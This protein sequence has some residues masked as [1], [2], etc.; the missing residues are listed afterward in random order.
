MKQVHA[1]YYNL[2]SLEKMEVNI[3]LIN[4]IEKPETNQNQI[5]VSTRNTVCRT[6]YGKEKSQ[7]IR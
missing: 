1:R 3:T 5:N 4:F 2:H 7:N 6:Y